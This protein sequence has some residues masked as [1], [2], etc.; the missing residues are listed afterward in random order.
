[1]VA[2]CDPARYQLDHGGT[3]GGCGGMFIKRVEF[4]VFNIGVSESRFLL[5][6]FRN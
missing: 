4:D 2:I 6:I 1:M 3:T 5:P